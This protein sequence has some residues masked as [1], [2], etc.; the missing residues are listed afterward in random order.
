MK[1]IV[2]KN[3]SNAAGV[4]KTAQRI[5]TRGKVASRQLDLGRAT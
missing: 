3:F 4:K 2:I 5:V 1:V